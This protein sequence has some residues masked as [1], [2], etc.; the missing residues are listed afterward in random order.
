M[1]KITTTVTHRVS[2]GQYCNLSPTR[3]KNFPIEQRCRFC[4]NVGKSTFVC[5][6]HNLPL[7]VEEGCL[8]RKA[9]Q[10]L[11]NMFQRGLT[12]TEPDVPQIN[13]KELMKWTMDEFDKIYKN[14]LTA[15]Y[16]D[17]LAMKTAREHVLK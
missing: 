11:R 10:C 7:V 3:Y 17:A 9:P 16:P 14:L 13:P 6:M 8:I 4:T 15:G 5:V 2:D 12:V 1:K